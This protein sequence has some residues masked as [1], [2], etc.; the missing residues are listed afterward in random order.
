MNTIE[1]VQTKDNDLR[2]KIKTF[3]VKLDK[4][5]E[6]VKEVENVSKTVARLET[7][8]ARVSS[9]VDDVVA[10]VESKERAHIIKETKTNHV[11]PPVTPVRAFVGGASIAILILGA[12]LAMWLLGIL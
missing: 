8:I 2:D 3:L 11:T 12:L 10:R 7:Q 6:R 1:A 4:M 5:E 9:R